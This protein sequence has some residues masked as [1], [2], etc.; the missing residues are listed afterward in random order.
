MTLNPG[1]SLP[2]ASPT[3]VA[4]FDRSLAI[5]EVAKTLGGARCAGVGNINLR[6][7]IDHSSRHDCFFSERSAFLRRRP[8]HVAAATTNQLR[9]RK[10]L[11]AK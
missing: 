7:R 1:S 5:A 9:R 2:P 6:G 10:T 11:G 8:W 4:A 3:N